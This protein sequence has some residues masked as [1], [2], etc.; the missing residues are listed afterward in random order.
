MLGVLPETAIEVNVFT[1][2]GAVT[3]IRA[4]P[5]MPF[6]E[7]LIVAEPTAS[8][9]ANPEGLTV[10]MAGAAEVQATVEVTSAVEPSL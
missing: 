8:A 6:S 9:V 4:D 2:E 1:T 7:A 5:M 3:V 10:A